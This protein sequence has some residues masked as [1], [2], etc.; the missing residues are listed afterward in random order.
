MRKLLMGLIAA[1]IAIALPS[2]GFTPAFATGGTSVT[3]ESISYAETS[4]KA[5]VKTETRAVIDGATQVS[6]E[7]PNHNVRVTKKQL[8]KAVRIKVNATGSNSS[9][10][11]FQ[12]AVK[13]LMKSKH[14]S[15][16]Q[17]VK[18]AGIVVLKKG[19]CVRNTGRENRLQVGF[20]WCLA[21]DAVLVFDKPSKQYRHAY[22][23]RDGRLIKTCLNYIGGDVPMR[24][25]VIQVRYEEDI[26]M[27]ID[28]E[29]E[30]SVSATVKGS[31]SC[32]TGTLY[33][34]ASASAS[35]SASASIRVKIR[36]K[37]TAVEAKKIELL[38][39]A[40]AKAKTAAEAAAMARVKLECG[41]TPT[42]VTPKP[43]LIEISTINDVL[44][45]NSRTITVS[46]NVAPGHT[47][48]LFC[49]SRNGGSITAGKQQSVSGSFTKQITYTA[50]SE[51]PGPNAEYGIAAGRDRVDCTVTQDDGQKDDISTNQF[52][53]RPAPVDP[54]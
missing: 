19:S 7:V 47:G 17:A 28:L 54:L 15:R 11:I 2:V 20:V 38:T 48:T 30:V 14:M 25:K 36:E 12:T 53:I 52:E 33:G 42:P 21:Y 31:Q 37:V 16:K 23:I 45:N 41:E 6:W 18:A 32:P 34:E 49:T 13:K 26:L 5:E 24:V 35:G 4:A 29:S 43:D 8:K 9:N 46:G 3:V 50:P 1:L 44:V 51:V 39:S 22:N 10:V 40:R 27:D